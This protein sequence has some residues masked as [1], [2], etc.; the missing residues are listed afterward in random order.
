MRVSLLTY[1]LFIE[2]NMPYGKRI[3][4]KR[5]AV[6]FVKMTDGSVYHRIN[7]IRKTLHPPIEKCDYRNSQKSYSWQ[8]HQFQKSSYLY[9]LVK[10]VIV[11]LYLWIGFEVIWHQHNRDLNMAQFIDL[12][13]HKVN[14]TRYYHLGGKCVEL[15][16]HPLDGRWVPQQIKRDNNSWTSR[17]GELPGWGRQSH[18]RR[19][20]L[21]SAGG[22]SACTPDPSGLAPEPLHLGSL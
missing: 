5:P 6:A 2:N 18:A 13:R 16:A 11:H 8:P 7:F 14:G 12:K 3:L 20:V 9:L 21:P 17:A 1:K 4:P 10:K 15:S 22:R 19:L